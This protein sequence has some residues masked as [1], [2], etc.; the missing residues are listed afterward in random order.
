MA[1]TGTSVSR[2]SASAIAARRRSRAAVMNGV[3][4][5]PDTGSGITFL[6]PSA[7]ACRLAAA[8]P[9]GDPAM[10]TCPGAL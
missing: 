1:I 7:L 9:S 3:W 2:G 8:T 4:N 6:A 5:A 10:T